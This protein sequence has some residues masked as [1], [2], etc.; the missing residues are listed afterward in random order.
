MSNRGRENCFPVREGGNPGEDSAAC[1][2][3][4]DYEL[5][6]PRARAWYEAMQQ[7]RTQP[8]DFNQDGTY[9]VKF[10]DCLETIAERSIRMVGGP[11]NRDAI[12]AQVNAIVEAN[13]DRY[14]TLDCNRDYIRDGWKLKVPRPQGR[15]EPPPVRV[16]PPPVRVEPPPPIEPP[17]NDRP[18]TN[19]FPG[20]DFYQFNG[21]GRRIINMPGA[22]L[23][24]FNGGCNRGNF[25]MPMYDMPRPELPPFVYD[26]PRP[27]PEPMPWPDQPYCGNR[28]GRCYQ[29]R[30]YNGSQSGR[31]PPIMDRIP[32]L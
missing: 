7:S 11:V 5:S 1:N 30:S 26:M 22:N 6:T 29:R 13:H 25:D 17:F 2:F 10:G 14:K 21:G 19:C 3:K 9:T 15:P 32:R 12:N 20:K 16:E 8:L 28:N 18:P 31:I 4:P 27:I 24:I 23:Y